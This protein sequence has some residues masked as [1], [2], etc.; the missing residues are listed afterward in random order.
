MAVA[1]VDYECKSKSK[2]LLYYILLQLLETASFGNL[3]K[4][5]LL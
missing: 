1:F 3:G 2:I 4:T 5:V